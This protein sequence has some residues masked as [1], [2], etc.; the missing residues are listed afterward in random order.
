M[1]KDGKY[2]VN[3]KV[4]KDY[5]EKNNLT[6][7]EFAKKCNIPPKAMDIILSKSIDYPLIY[8]LRI[9]RK[10]NIPFAD[11]FIG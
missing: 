4:I 7:E 1:N 3:Q 2:V 11:M 5:M 8:L 6:K 9:A 10:I